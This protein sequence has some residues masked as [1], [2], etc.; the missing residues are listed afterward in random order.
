MNFIKE[1]FSYLFILHV[2]VL[3]S[4]FSLRAM[5]LVTNKTT[6]MDWGYKRRK[7]N[8]C[9]CFP[10]KDK[11]VYPYFLSKNK[12]GQEISDDA[13]CAACQDTFGTDTF[14][15]AWNEIPSRR[16]SQKKQKETYNVR[17]LNIIDKGTLWFIL[18]TIYKDYEEGKPLKIE[19]RD[20]RFAHE[21]SKRI[22]QLPLAIKAAI[23]EKTGSRKMMVNDKLRLL[24]LDTILDDE[25]NKKKCGCITASS[26]MTYAFFSSENYFLH[27]LRQPLCGLHC[28]FSAVISLI[29]GSFLL[30]TAKFC[31]NETPQQKDKR[32]G[33]QEHS[34][35]TEMDYTIMNHK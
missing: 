35:L 31:N 26:G 2:L 20:A 33:F 25:D 6:T 10:D 30:C 12:R 28:A 23:A 4:A 29:V 16:S 15:Y 21:M 11:Q 14:T 13:L 9:Y 18:V 24:Y 7:D 27:Q 19:G 32:H 5:E 1:K 22:L 34:I 3:S 8:S 17:S